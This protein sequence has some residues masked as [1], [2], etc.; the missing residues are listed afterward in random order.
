MRAEEPAEGAGGSAASWTGRRVVLRAV[1]GQR[2]LITGASVLAAS[3]QACEALVPVVIGVLIDEAVST[4]SVAA[5]V[6]WLVILAVLFTVLSYSYRFAARGAERASEQAAHRLRIELGE[7]V[8]DP[9]GG[10]EAG[11]LPGALVNIATEDAKRVGRVNGAVPFGVAGVAGLLVSAVALLVISTPLGLLVLLGTPPLLWLAHVIGRPLERRSG[12]EQERAAH[13]SGTAADL[14]SGL[15]VLKGIGAENAAVTRYREASRNSLAAT[16]RATRAQAG[17]DGALFALTGGFIALVALVGG[18]LAIGG[19]ISIGDLVAAVGLAQF[20]LGPFQIFSW[21]NGMLAQGRASAE[22]VA[23]VLAAP[24]AVA[25]GD[26]RLPQE[27][28]G[29]LRLKGVTH[30]ALHDVDLDIAPGRLTGVVAPDPAAAAALLE[31]LGRDADPATGSI[32]LDGVELSGLHPSDVRAA[33]LVAAHDADLF[34]GTLWE[35]VTAAVSGA[36]E[37]KAEDTDPSAAMSA[38]VGRALT[39]A[40]ADEVASTLPH[41]VD[42]TITERGRSLSGGQRQRVALARALAADPPVLV[43]HDPTTAVD[44]VTESRVASEIAEVRR[45]RT[46]VLVTTSPALLA[47]TDRVVVIDGGT[48]TAAGTH[49]ELLHTDPAYRSAVLT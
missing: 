30:G 33:I 7:R 9:Q 49:T 39:A 17:H 19:S 1:S 37:E 22:R 6:R 3:H 27:V 47:A 23:S 5:L 14:V 8:L 38:G 13:A 20:L 43:V 4:G 12:V 2:R 48:V 44:A 25:A 35:N 10:A 45:G 21:V 40:A 18:H 16:L 28:T 36:A 46:T 42:T 24:P 29:R 26:G 15:R 41:G 32:E 11:R 34:E 31:C